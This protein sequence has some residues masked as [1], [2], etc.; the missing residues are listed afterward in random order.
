MLYLYLCLYLALT[1]GC[2]AYSVSA[3]RSPFAGFGK[4]S[5]PVSASPTSEPLLSAP[6]ACGSGGTYTDCCHPYHEGR[7]LPPHPVALVRSRFSALAYKKINYIMSTTHPD[8]K[9]YVEAEQR[10]KRKAWERD[11]NDFSNEF[12]FLAL[13][14]DDEARDSNVSPMAT[15]ATVSFTAKLRRSAYPDRAPEDLKE[16]STFTKIAT[17][18]GDKWLYRDAQI[19]S[20]LQSTYKSKSTQ[21]VFKTQRKF[22]SR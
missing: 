20:G 9:E 6:C 3:S 2:A 14:F 5:A 21:N 11:L 17:D 19:L 10:S 22:T 1:A 13:N 12:D 8:H 15:N 16:V 4:P 18:H 7:L